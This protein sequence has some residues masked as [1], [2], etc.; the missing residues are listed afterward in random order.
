MTKKR[1]ETAA[2]ILLSISCIDKIQYSITGDNI[3]SAYHILLLATYCALYLFIILQYTGTHWPFS[4]SSI[5]L[6]TRHPSSSRA[7]HLSPPPPLQS[8]SH[9][10]Q[11]CVCQTLFQRVIHSRFQQQGDG[12]DIWGSIQRSSSYDPR[13]SSGTPGD[14]PADQCEQSYFWCSTTGLRLF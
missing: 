11:V 10:G 9:K 12:E 1:P 14:V 5:I 3:H 7:S 2:N 13:I 6:R 8:Y 4:L